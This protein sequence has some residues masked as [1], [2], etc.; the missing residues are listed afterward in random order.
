[1][2]VFTKQKRVGAN[3]RQLSI[4]AKQKDRERIRAIRKKI[5]KIV[6]IFIIS[7]LSVTV[8]F[9]GGKYVLLYTGYEKFA[10][11][12]AIEVSGLDILQKDEILKIGALNTGMPMLFAL[13]DDHA[14]KIEEHPWVKRATVS[15]KLPGKVIVTIK[16][17]KPVALVNCG[18]VCITDIDGY[19]Y[20]IV[21]GKYWNL[22]IVSGLE[23]ILES[24]NL[25]KLSASS[26]VKI[27]TLFKAV[28]K[29][30]SIYLR[31]I[32]EIVFKNTNRVML[33]LRPNATKVE[34][35]LGSMQKSLERLTKVF[36]YYN[37]NALRYP[38]AIK[39]YSDNIAY[40]K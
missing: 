35:D 22:P 1:M 9:V 20:P 3:Q 7:V 29:K 30:Q 38:S 5:V 33:R 8:L 11:V 26:L 31:N 36:N 24:K 23:Y 10:T 14:K 19:L 27:K 39:F 37:D 28:N 40:V 21:V 17:R 18:T 34:F 25:Y 32:S 6:L 15:W 2:A 16:E 13:K 12:N 4:E